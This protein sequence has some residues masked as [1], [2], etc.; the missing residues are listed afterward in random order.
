MPASIPYLR[1]PKTGNKIELEPSEKRLAVLFKED[2]LMAFKKT[3]FEIEKMP[4]NANLKKIS[5]RVYE[6]EYVDIPSDEEIKVITGRLQNELKNVIPYKV[7]KAKDQYGL[8]YITDE[9][10]VTFSAGT[11]AD[12]IR[13]LEEK[14]NLNKI[15]EYADDQLVCVFAQKPGN[16]VNPIEVA[17]N[18]E[19]EKGVEIAEPNLIN[20]LVNTATVERPTDDFF[21]KQWQLETN[22]QPNVFANADVNA[23]EAWDRLNGGGDPTVI[24]AVVDFGFDLTHPDLV[25]KIVKP[26][27][28]NETNLDKFDFAAKRG[29]PKFPKPRTTFEDHGTSC[30]GI[31]AAEKNENGVVGIAFGCKILPVRCP[32]DPSNFELCKIFRA[33]RDKADVISC[34]YAPEVSAPASPT[35]ANLIEKIAKFEGRQRQGC[36]ICFAAG[37]ANLPLNERVVKPTIFV[38][39]RPQ[40]LDFTGRVLNP[41]ASHD[42]VIAVAASTAKNKKA[43]YSNWGREIWVCAPSND[44]EEEDGAFIEPS[45]TTTSSRGNLGN[46][47]YTDRFTGTSAA[48][49]LVA[50]I[51]ALIISANPRLTADEVKDIIKKTADKINPNDNPDGKYDNDNDGRSKWYGF[52]KVNAG[53][54]VEMALGMR[55]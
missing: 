7:Y 21:S 42:D 30:A 1:E 3:L 36:V 23:R 53:R 43:M 8:I 19:N 11:S 45:I 20:R 48:T 12:S 22:N 5:S 51:A 40:Q 54:A 29:A 9:I 34:S 2:D 50:G 4:L 24:I 6:I 14:Y 35:L 16:W 10:M 25:N 41:Y 27:E 18:M 52:G 47:L 37:N 49:P 38:K 33:I 17:N 44:I 46:N 28:I 32:D 26:E 15:D 31:A 55:S 39:G 13:L